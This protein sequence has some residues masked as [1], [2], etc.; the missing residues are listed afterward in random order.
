MLAYNR[1]PNI[2]S[3]IWKGALHTRLGC[4]E[5]REESEGMKMAVAH[6][7]CAAWAFHSLPDMYPQVMISQIRLKKLSCDIWYIAMIN[8]RAKDTDISPMRFSRAATSPCSPHPSSLSV[9]ISCSQGR[10][11]KLKGRG[12]DLGKGRML[13]K[14]NSLCEILNKMSAVLSLNFWTYKGICLILIHPWLLHALGVSKL[15]SLL[16]CS[17]YRVLSGSGR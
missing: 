5:S 12:R 1:H 8:F 16:K 2:I 13:R 7:Q 3:H 17:I 11:K 15:S 14:I 6:F 4:A 9:A 10:T